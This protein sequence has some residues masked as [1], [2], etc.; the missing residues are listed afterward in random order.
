MT[1][2]IV[3]VLCSAPAAARAPKLGA[4]ELARVL[5][6]EGL[7]ACVNVLPGVES[8]YRWQGAVEHGSELLLVAK[9]TLPYV[10]ALQA[11]LLALHP[12]D[13]PEVLELP[14]AGGAHAYLDWLRASVGG[15]SAADA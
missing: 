14:V 3:V 1:S 13:V 5:V 4:H 11:R 2:D 9:T 8:Y 7:C 15:A 12:Y 10:E 6:T